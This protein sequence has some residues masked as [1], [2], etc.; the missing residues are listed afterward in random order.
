MMLDGYVANFNGPA[1]AFFGAI[2]GRY[3][4][5][6]AHGSFTL[7][8]KKYSLPL[9]NGENSLHGGPHGFNNVVWKAKPIANGVELTLSEQGR[10]SRI[11]R[12]LVGRGSLYAE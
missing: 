9:N 6:I 11:S 7:D 1:N 3:A 12:Q 4:N 5:R 8:G 10:R 2:I